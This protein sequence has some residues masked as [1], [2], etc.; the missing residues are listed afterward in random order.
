MTPTTFF[1]TALAL[2]AALAA[3]LAAAAPAQQKLIPQQSEIAFTTRQMGVPV[4]GRFKKFDAQ[5]AFDPKHPEAGKVSIA[6]DAASASFGIA[7]TD[8]ELPKPAWFGAA[9]FPQATFQSTAIKAAGPN[10]FD[11]AGRLS[12][13]GNARDVIVPVTLAQAGATT[14]A[15]GSFTIKRLDFKIGEGEWTDTSLVAND[16]VVKFSLAF[17][18]VGAP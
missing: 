6:I 1:R 4:E 16:V 18:G 15:T 2:A 9:K 10:R 7:D 14:R 3:L 8:A 11:V 17:S 5:L 13:K 12:A